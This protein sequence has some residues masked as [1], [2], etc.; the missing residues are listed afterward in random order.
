MK[1]IFEFLTPENPPLVLFGYFT[2]LIKTDGD[3]LKGLVAV[4]VEFDNNLTVA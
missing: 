3:T 4:V 1:V 2:S